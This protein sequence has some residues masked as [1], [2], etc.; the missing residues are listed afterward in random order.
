MLASLS[1]PHP[2]AALAFNP[3][4]IIS[5]EEFFDAEDMT[6]EEVQAFLS[7]KKSTLADYTVPAPDGT[8]V[9]AADIIW[10]S[11]KK[12]GINPKVLLV[13]LQ[14]EQSLIENPRP[15]QYN[16]DWATGYARCDACPASDPVVAAYK[17][18]A[19]QVEKAAARKKYYTTNPQEFTYRAG[20]QSIVDGVSL[21]PQNNAT[22]A[23]Y[24]YTP[25]LRG[26]FSFWKLWQRYFGKVFPDGMLVK[27]DDTPDIW[28]IQ[29]GKKR[30]I[31]SMSVFHS[32]YSERTLVTVNARSLETYAEGAP[33]RFMQY[34]LAQVP[35]GG[36]FLLADD[37]KYIIPSRAIFR[38]IGFNPDEV[39]RVLES[40]LID[41]PTV[42]VLSS[43]QSPIEEL[44]QDV[45]TGGVFALSRGVKHPLLERA[46]MTT[47]FSRMPI[48]PDRTHELDA[49]ALGEPVLF[50]DGTLVKA[51]NDPTVYIISH[52]QKRPFASEE[53][54]TSLGFSWNQIITSTGTTLVYHPLGE[55]VDTGRIIDDEFPENRTALAA[56]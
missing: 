56:K 53:A 36:I 31:T 23:L 4:Q 26:N 16:Y 44:V 3:E 6:A 46:I 7:R 51:D 40:D 38:E 11:G 37:G 35:T 41:I 29:D 10:E 48:R 19:T 15:S 20:V 13:L 9:N 8:R 32:R 21:I 12:N 54:F 28:L 2:L 50:S 43:T 52:G 39:V 24:N 34:A 27:E 30:R 49:L 25:H 1:V 5:D 33:V 14:K 55:K 45:R 18:F 22:A 47:N 42:G 17:G